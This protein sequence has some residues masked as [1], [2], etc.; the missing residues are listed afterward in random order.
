VTGPDHERYVEDVGAYLLGALADDEREAFER[1]LTGCSICREELERLRPA[2][3]ALPRS[4]A[5]VGPPPTLKTSLMEA[6]ERETGVPPSAERRRTGRRLLA[7]LT[8][9]RPALAWMSAA[10]LLAVGAAVGFGLS[11]VGGAGGTRTIAA[12]VDHSRVPGGSA[13]LLVPKGR[14]GGILRVR[15]LPILSHGRVYEVW[16]KRNGD[17]MPESTFDVDRRGAGAAA[18]P[19][20]LSGASAVLVT[21]EPRGGSRAPTEAPVMSAPL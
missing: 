1:H 19:E 6:I 14:A 20:D 9:M 7:G 18:V 2:V 12:R 4:V 21:R 11:R 16:V 3:E 15:G 8:G 17:L 13:S 5:Q 10:L